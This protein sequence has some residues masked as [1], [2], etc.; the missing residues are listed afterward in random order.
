MTVMELRKLLQWC[1][2]AD[3]D[4]GFWRRLYY[5]A[6]AFDLYTRLQIQAMVARFG[7]LPE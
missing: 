4:A 1:D 7:V 6:F 3:D 5:A 2:V